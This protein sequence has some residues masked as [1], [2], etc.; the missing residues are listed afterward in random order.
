MWE[1]IKLEWETLIKGLVITF[2][3]VFPFTF[4]PTLIAHG[5]S[6]EALLRRVP[7][8]TLYSLGIAVLVMSFVVYDNYRKLL[9]KKQLYDKPAFT[10]LDFYGRI[11]GIGSLVEGLSTFL[12][13][14][15]K[16]YY[17]KIEIDIPD[18][19]QEAFIIKIYP[20]L[21]AVVEFRDNEEERQKIAEGLD[22]QLD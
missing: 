5:F 1:I 8:S 7:T 4:I 11:G 3:L 20:V 18:A 10:A 21:A 16:L 2:L 15:W 6:G 17:F 14:K 13:G 9:R 12:V 22:S 19:H